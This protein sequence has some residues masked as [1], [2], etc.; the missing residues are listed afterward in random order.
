MKKATA[1]LVISTIMVGSMFG[2]NR[3]YN[4]DD[5]TTWKKYKGEYVDINGTTF[6]IDDLGR[7]VALDVER[8]DREVGIFYF[9]WTGSHGSH[10]VFD[11]TEILKKNP[12]APRSKK[13][14]ARAG[15]SPLYGASHWWGK[16]LFSYYTMLDDYVIRKHVQMFVEA[17]ID[18]LMIDATNTYI[19]EE[20]SLLLFRILDEYSR[21][22]WK[23]PKVSYY[24][25]TNTGATIERIYNDIYM[26]HPEYE[27]LWYCYDGK[28]LI[29]GDMRDSS[30][31]KRAKEF[32]TMKDSYMNAFEVLDVMPDGSFKYDLNKKKNMF[33]WI[34]FS[35][36]PTEMKDENGNTWMM[37]VSVAEICETFNSVYGYLWETKDHS[38]NWDGKRNRHWIEGEE[39]SYLYGINFARQFEY[40]IE[41]D[42]PMIFICGWNEWIAG[43]WDSDRGWSKDNQLGKY[44]DDP[45]DMCMFVDN[46]NIDHSR[47]IEPMTGGYGDNYYMQ[48]CNF[49]RQYKGTNGRVNVGKKTTVDIN[50]D[51]SQWDDATAVYK[52]FIN[53]TSIR[54]VS[55]YDK[56]KNIDISEYENN[57]GRNDISVMKVARD[58]KHFYFYVDTVEDISDPTDNW[59][60]LFLATGFSK[61]K[62]WNGYDFVVNRTAPPSKN[63]AVLEKYAGDN[64]WEK[65]AEVDMRVEGNKLMLKVPVSKIG[66]SSMDIVNLQFKWAD[67]CNM[68]NGIWTFYQDGDA[69]PYGR[70]NFLFSN[71]A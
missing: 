28:P 47:D 59:M 44:T 20:Q 17:D 56:W 65:V 23:V 5:I 33:P 15:G 19:Y 68:D 18:Y 61:T 58:D 63:K 54:D 30:I 21:Q 53:D 60:T 43:N 48:M 25:H 50:G 14:W 40:A 12:D 42:P 38:R 26:A 29:V 7:A 10:Q 62:K 51:W 66:I 4:Y 49:I 41:K 52:D 24:T 16:P 55:L 6:C 3:K 45:R 57:T 46:F 37:T 34:D 70:F 22:G 8:K 36:W 9:L 27:H 69:A 71:K 31:S 2:C 67:N 32:F 39:D 64:K 1:F 35:D 11:N 13:E